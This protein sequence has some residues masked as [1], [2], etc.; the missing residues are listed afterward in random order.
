[1]FRTV[2]LQW[3]LFFKEP[4]Q[5]PSLFGSIKSKFAEMGVAL[6]DSSIK[7]LSLTSSS[8]DGAVLYYLNN[9]SLFSDEIED[10]LA[11]SI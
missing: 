6:S 10:S 11:S 7:R 5:P 2:L 8:L 1:V 4:P 9:M 3:L